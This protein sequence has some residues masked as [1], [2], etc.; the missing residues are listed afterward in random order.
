MK[1]KG[2][3]KY[4]EIIECI[5]FSKRLKGNMGKKEIK[6]VLLFP[7][8]NSIHTFFMKKKIDIV[9]IDKNNIVRFYYNHLSPYKIIWPKKNVYST[10]EFPEGENI[11]QI[12]DKIIYKKEE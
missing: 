2:K 11:Y 5:N 12:N 8:C 1:I 9:M 6:E 3:S 4:W 7:K 10:L